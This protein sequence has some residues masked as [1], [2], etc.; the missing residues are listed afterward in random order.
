M[1][2]VAADR[3]GASDRIRV[4]TVAEYLAAENVQSGYR[5]ATARTDFSQTKPYTPPQN[6]STY[7]ERL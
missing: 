6:I 4:T 5:R 2:L 7:L 3:L 1:I